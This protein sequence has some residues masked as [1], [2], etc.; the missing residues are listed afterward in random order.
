MEEMKAGIEKIIKFSENPNP[1]AIKKPAHN[2]PITAPNL[3][4]PIPQPIP[5]VLNSEGY[6]LEATEYK[7]TKPPWM[8]NP[9]IPKTINIKSDPTKKSIRIIITPVKNKKE[10]IVFFTPNFE[11]K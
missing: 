7:P 8:A 4:I 10:D 11:E 3:P 6:I 2:G 5:V 1:E 9:K